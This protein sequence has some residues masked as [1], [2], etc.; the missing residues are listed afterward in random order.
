[1]CG[2]F[3]FDTKMIG[4]LLCLSRRHVCGVVMDTVMDVKMKPRNGKIGNSV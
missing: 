3:F 1:M 4:M 2:R